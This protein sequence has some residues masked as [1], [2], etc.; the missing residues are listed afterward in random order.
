MS[1][2]WIIRT[3]TFLSESYFVDECL[4]DAS[5]VTFSKLASSFL[6]LLD[7]S[8]NKYHKQIDLNQ[9][10]NRINLCENIMNLIIRL[11]DS[12][13][14]NSTVYFGNFCSASFQ[15]IYW[16]WVRPDLELK[17]THYSN[18]NTFE[19]WNNVPAFGL[20]RSDQQMKSHSIMLL[21]H[22]YH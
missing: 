18:L 8:K 4:I 21:L 20:N 19:N 12:I 17:A 16:Y 7:N 10:L 15:R 22:F 6:R 14:N 13:V 2:C 9:L 3:Q 5:S 1:H 11:H